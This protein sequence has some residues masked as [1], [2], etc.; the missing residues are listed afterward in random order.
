MDDLE[1][2]EPGEPQAESRPGSNLYRSARPNIRRARPETNLYRLRRPSRLK[3]PKTCEEELKDKNEENAQLRAELKEKDNEITQLKKQVAAA[4]LK[5]Q[6][7]EFLDLDQAGGPLR[8]FD[9]LHP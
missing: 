4:E 7:G 5:G 6:Q 3:P 1:P 9:P 2:A 8:P